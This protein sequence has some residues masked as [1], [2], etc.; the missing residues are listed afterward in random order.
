MKVMSSKYFE[1]FSILSCLELSWIAHLFAGSVETVPGL[2]PGS[3]EAS[4]SVVGESALLDFAGE[5]CPLDSDW[6]Q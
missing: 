3:W 1:L 5:S 2:S 6:I 4:S